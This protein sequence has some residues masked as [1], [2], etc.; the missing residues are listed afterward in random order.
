MRIYSYDGRQESGVFPGTESSVGEAR[1]WLRKVLD[2]H[3]R[4]DDATLLLSEVFTNAVTHAG[5]SEVRVVV[6]VEWDGTVQVKVADQGAAT[7]PCVCACRRH[8]DDL[9]ECGR[10]IHLV[11]SLS[12]RWGFLK[13]AGGR[14]VWFTL[15]PREAMQGREP[16]GS[17]IRRRRAYQEE[18][19][20]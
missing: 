9:A 4:R 2:A 10:G 19:D 14:V 13:D 7:V 3:P 5:S 15:D 1:R 11:R 16:A 17:S 6:L 20:G 8:D 12:R 18:Q